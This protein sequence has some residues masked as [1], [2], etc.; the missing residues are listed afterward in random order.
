MSVGILL[1]L[2][3][4]GTVPAPAQERGQRGRAKPDTAQVFRPELPPA[5]VSIDRILDSLPLRDRIAQLVVPWIPGHYAAF[6]DSLFTRMQNWVDSLH[7]G[8][9]II[10]IGSPLDVAAKLNR[11]QTRSPLPLLIASDLEGGSHFRLV[12]GTPFPSNMGVGAAGREADAY[13]IGRITALEGR[14]VGI[15]LTF[16]PV[17]DLNNNPAN[18]II[19]TRSFGEDP[20]DVARLVAASVRGLQDF[21]MLATAKHF[22]GHGDTG[23][24]SHVS[25]PLITAPWIRFDTLELVPFRAA[26]DAGVAFVMSA[27]IAVPGLTGDSTR[28]ATLSADV[29]TGVLRDSLGFRGMIVTDALNM[30]GIVNAYGGGEG[31]VLAFLAGAD[32][33]L[34]PA[35][36]A[37][38]IDAMEQAVLTGRV[39]EG[40]LNRAV[41]RVLALKRQIGLFKRR[42]VELDSVPEV[43]GSARFLATARDIAQRAI[44]LVSDSLGVVDS[45]RQGPR[46]VTLIAYGD[47]GGPAVGNGVAAQL[48]SLGYPVSMFRIWPASGPASYDSAQALA[49]KNSTVIFTASVRATAWRGSIGLPVALAELIDLV[50]ADKPTVLVS[51][52]S[53]YIIAQT[54]RVSSYLIG[55]TS[56]PITEWA[57][58]RA[59]G[60]QAEITGHLPIAVPPHYVA[61]YG[62]QRIIGDPLEALRP[63]DT[64]GSGCCRP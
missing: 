8:G 32:L 47:E 14:A 17:A 43:V 42:T 15:H 63:P 1:L 52:G 54:P 27:H 62:L 29:I 36:P 11:L 61:G 26:V 53:P 60:G 18:P 59:L 50:A 6:D 46:T 19:N 39:D 23:T 64:A 2:V 10:S 13:E 51:L 5:P 28:P 9:L 48:R 16:A 30:G 4:L 25:L 3:V 57:V 40:E 31:A 22:P 58:G 33:L 49:R 37:L 44:V 38:A 34:Q 20:R 35:D 7:V 21:G 12:G 41:R 56:N 24:D 45:L 55:W